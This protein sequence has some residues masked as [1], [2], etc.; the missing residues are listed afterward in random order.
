LM[1]LGEL[2]YFRLITILLAFLDGTSLR[3]VLEILINSERN[4]GFV[5]A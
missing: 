3:L 4:L 1:C 5:I 2:I